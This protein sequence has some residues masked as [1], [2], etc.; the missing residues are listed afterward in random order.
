MLTGENASID[1]GFGAP[2]DP[3]IAQFDRADLSADANAAGGSPPAGS[4]RGT[5]PSQGI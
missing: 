5:A 1:D 4:L 2:L 3:I